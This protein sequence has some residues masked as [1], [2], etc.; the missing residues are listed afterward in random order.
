M[1]IDVHTHPPSHPNEVPEGE[2]KVDTVMR[3]GT[4]IPI[5]NSVADYLKVMEPVDKAFVFGLAP[6]PLKPD[7]VILSMD[8]WPKGFNQNDI[9]AEVAKRAPDKIIPFMSLH[10]LDPGVDDEYDRAVGDLGCKGI[11]LGPNYQYFDPVGEEAFRLYA[12][13]EADGIPAVFHQGTSPFWDAPL[14]WAHPLVMDRIAIRFPKFKVVMAH[15]GHPWHADTITVDASTRT[16]GP[17]FP[18]SSTGPGCSGTGC[19]S[20]TNGA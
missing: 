1:I 7:R 16:S 2:R 17:M 20:F 5:T 14:E 15:L 18:P 4:A 9:V 19:G 10:P 13:L 8:G 6:S 11:K 12:R 3:S